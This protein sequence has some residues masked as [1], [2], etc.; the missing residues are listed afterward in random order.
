MSEQSDGGGSALNRPDAVQST[1]ASPQRTSG[2]RQNY[3]QGQRRGPQRNNTRPQRFQG[4]TQD[5]IL[6]KHIFDVGTIQKSQDLFV[7]TAKEIGEYISREYDDAGEFRNAF[8]DLRYAEVLTEPERPTAT[9]QFTILIWTEE[10]KEY[11]KKLR[12]RKKNEEKAFPLLLGQCS[13][14]IVQ[15]IEATQRWNS[16]SGTNDVLGLLE[17]IRE[18][19]YTG[20]TRRKDTTAL[21][22][23]ATKLFAF[24]QPDGMSLHD[25]FE[26]FKGLVKIY[27]HHGGCLGQDQTRIEAHLVDPDIA[28][29]DEIALARERA[30]EE[31]QAI[32]FL[33]KA[34]T[35]QYGSLLIDLHNRFAGD[36]DQYP[37]TLNEAYDRLVNYINPMKGHATIA[38]EESGMAF[39]VEDDYAPSKQATDESPL[40]TG[41]GGRGRGGRGRGGRGRGR[42]GEV[43]ASDHQPAGVEATNAANDTSNASPPYVLSTPP[44]ASFPSSIIDVTGAET[45]IISAHHTADQIWLLLDSC[46][47]VNLISDKDLLTDIHPVPHSLQVRCNAGTVVIDHQGYLGGYPE[48]VWFNPNG[49][50]NLMSLH[51]VQRYYQVILNTTKDNAFYINSSKGHQTR[52]E[53]SGH[54]LYHYAMDSSNNISTLWGGLS[55]RTHINTVAANANG[56][57]RRQCQ[58]AQR[59][60]HLQ[61]IVMHPGDRDMKEIVIKHLHDCPVT[62]ADIDV[63][64]TL[65]G[66]NLGSLKGKTVRRPNPHVPMGI[67]GVP[68]SIMKHHQRVTI[69][70]DIM[71]INAIP[72]FIT[73]S[74]NL[75]FGTVEVLPNRQETT[76]KNKLRAVTHLYEQRGFRVTSIMA[77]PEFEP[78]RAVFPQLNTC[79]ADEH[80]P[81]IERFIRTVKDRVRSVYHS[82]PYKY[83]PRLLLVHLVKAA[84][85]WLNAFPHRDGISDQSPRYIMT[86]QTLNFQRHAR[87]ELGAYVQTHEEHDNSMGPRTLGAICLGPTGNQQ[88]GHW[89]LSLTS[90]ARII[91]HRWTSLPA[92]RE[93]IRRV[94]SMG[95]HQGMPSTLTFANRVGTEI[96]DAVRDLYDNASDDGSEFDGDDDSYSAVSQDDSSY[97][98]SDY[99]DEAGSMADDD[100]DS[101]DDRSSS[102]DDDDNDDNDDDPHNIIHMDP[103]DDP[104]SDDDNDDPTSDDESV[105][106]RHTEDDD[107]DHSVASN[108]TGVDEPPGSTEHLVSETTGVDKQPVDNP[109]VEVDRTGVDD[110]SVTSEPQQPT[111]EE[112]FAEAVAAGQ[113]DAVKSNTVRPTRNK[114]KNLDPAFVYLDSVRQ[115]GPQ[116]FAFLT[117][118][119]S[120]KRGLKQ[121][122]KRGADAIMDELRQL[123]YRNVMRGVKRSDMSREETKSAL[124]YLMFLKEKRS[125][126]I[127]GRGCADGRK[128]RLYKGKDETSSPT[129]FIESLFLSSM[130]DAHEH[131]K[132]MTL[133]IPGAFMQTDIDETIHIRL[134]GPLADLLIKVDPSYQDYVCHERGQR[135]I[136]TCLNKALYGTL[137][138]AMLFWKELTKFVTADLGFTINPYDSCVANKIID[139]KQCTILWH[140]DDIKM[141]HVSQ[142]VLE[143]LMKRIEARFGK[144]APLTVTRGPVH[145]YL[146]MTIDFSRPGTV[147]FHMKAFIDD[148]I[149]ETPSELLKGMAASPAGQH[150]FNVNENCPKLSK[151]QA[152]LFHHLTA[153]LLYLSK[154]TRP[155]IQTAVAFLTTRV[156]SPDYDDYKKLGRCLKYV[157]EMKDIPLVLEAVGLHSICWW[158]DASFGVHPNLRSHTG[159]TLSFGKGSPFAVSCKQKLNTRS[160]TEAELVGVNDAMSLILWTRRFMEAQGYMIRDNVILQDNQS[161]MLLARNGQQSSGKATRHIDVRYYFVKDQI[162]KKLMRL[163]Y[164]PTDLMVADILTKPLQGTQFRRLR[165]RLLNYADPVLMSDPQECVG[166]H[167]PGPPSSPTAG[168]G[169]PSTVVMDPAI[170]TSACGGEAYPNKDKAAAIS[171]SMAQGGEA[172]P[173]KDKAAAIWRSRAHGREA[174]PNKDKAAAMLRSREPSLTSVEVV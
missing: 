41:R 99:S 119:M 28:T 166:A 21:V 102:D 32:L 125:G 91:R 33:S 61:N 19:M 113:A 26:T 106:S 159:A 1:S 149:A 46:S 17:L 14:T 157:A 138:A 168:A 153:K 147:Q 23:A 171:R 5:P 71:F 30:G 96:R 123:V 90:G 103:N 72:F 111:E 60:R 81:E 100:D 66:P 12:N 4:K 37:E 163:E 82:L 174:Y 122:G 148:L 62:G 16:V 117:E 118:Q 98:S 165:A 109:A 13:P 124:Q 3:T 69:A 42:G 137:Q 136:Y 22:E 97:R 35:K 83:V 64:R 116:L 50:A 8:I 53:P 74:R 51:N 127:K 114:K 101:V 78:L 18:A 87:L 126:K 39:L 7:T 55:A 86:G 164:C 80:V 130:I 20:T 160:S 93:V 120:A 38:S 104:T 57:T 65:L 29:P 146:G 89:F 129:V 135:V 107:D 31:F 58:N 142:D 40:R 63:A 154:R 79:G 27:E 151:E 45:H 144:E 85:F 162:D 150:L 44:T 68:D 141:S 131:R 34:N 15:R 88:G 167:G 170:P 143:S 47:T 77:D 75:H 54:G 70:I 56:F 73:I 76:I 172:Y 121:F 115:S 92:P 48:P 132:V 128:Q 11:R 145:E 105:I 49:I 2:R 94:N 112:K 133:D 169:L 24:R 134:D 6:R 140:V 84:V 152:E 36:D 25:Y 110:S 161:T 108:T 52:W 59:A 139:G 158:V 155:D 9:D 10:M 156:S 43:H 173:N 95:K 67:A